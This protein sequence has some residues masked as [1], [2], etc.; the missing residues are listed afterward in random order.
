[1]YNVTDSADTDTP[2]TLRNAINTINTSTDLTNTITISPSVVTIVLTSNLP[3]ISTAAANALVTITTSSSA[4]ING[5]DSFR[6]FATH[7]ASLALLNL[8]L[9]DGVA[10]GG[11]GMD[12]VQRSGGGGGGL[13]A[14]GGVFIDLGQTLTLT[15]TTISSCRA[16]GGNGGAGANTPADGIGGSGGGASWSKAAATSTTPNVG[17]GDFPGDHQDG[18]ASSEGSTGY[19]GGNGGNG[20][21]GSIGGPGGGN[22][23][24]TPAVT[25]QGGNGGYCGGG[26][27]GSSGRA[28]GGGGNGGGDGAVTVSFTEGGGGGGYGSG[29]AGGKSVDAVAAGGGGGFG[30]GG[31]GGG[32]LSFAGGAGGGGGGFGGGGGGGTSSTTPGVIGARGLG[33]SYGGAGGQGLSSGFLTAGGGG[34]AGIGGGIFVAD[35]ATLLINESVFLSSNIAVGGTGGTAPGNPG[36]SGSGLANDVFLFRGASLSFT[37][38]S[39]LVVN[40]AIQGDTA[41]TGSNIDNGITINPS[42]SGAVITLSNTNTYQGGTTISNGTLSI[43]T[44]NNIGGSTAGFSLEG[45]TLHTTGNVT[46]SG[47][48]SVT[49]NSTIFTDPAV[50]TTLSGTLTGTDSKTLTLSGTGTTSLATV[51]VNSTDVF[52]IAG[53]IGGSQTLIKSGTGTLFLTG[54]ST[55]SAGTT[56]NA[57]IVNIQNST[58]LG[59]G[60]ASVTSGTQLQVQGGITAANALALNGTGGGTGA[61]LNISGNNTFNGAITLGSATT[62]GSTAGTLTLNTISGAQALTFVGAG[63]TTV[64]GAITTGTGTL[65][66]SGTGTLTLKGAN[67][68]SGVTAINAG[69]L[70]IQNNTALGS[71]AVSLTSGAQL[72]MQGGITATNA[73]TLNGTGGGTGALLN[74]SG[75]NSYSGP[76]TLGSATTIG[77]TADT[78]TLGGISETQ[79]L[80]FT[81]AGNTTVGGAIAIATGILTKSGAGTLSLAGTSTYTGNTNVLNG[82]LI[83][84]GSIV[85]STLNLSSGTR[86]KGTGSVGPLNVSSGATVAPG[87]SIGTLNS[88][89]VTFDPG[90]IFSVEIS[91]SAASLLDVTGTATL[92]GSVEVVVDPGTYSPSGE[93][94]ILQA[95]SIS[96]N[97]DPTVIGGNGFTF[98]LNQM[99]N[100]IYLLYTFVPPPVPTSTIAT[101]G[102]SGNALKI[103]HYLNQNA[104]SSTLALL[105]GLTGGSLKSALNSVSPARNA[106]ATYITMQTAFSLSELVISHMDDLRLPRETSFQDQFVSAL[107]ADS[108]DCPTIL[109]SSQEPKNKFSVWAAGFGEFA[110]QSASLQNPSFNFISEAAL[111]GLDYYGENRVVVGGSLGYAHTHYHEDHHAGHGN[112]NY[113]FASLYGNGFIGNFY[114]S[115]AIWGIFNQTEN[116]RN[117]SFPGF[118]EKAHADIFAWQL[119][120]HLEVGYN[121]QLC[122]GNI[123]PFTSVDWAIS[124]QREYKEHGAS[125]FN[126]KQKANNSSMVRSETGLKFCEKWEK[127]WGAFFLTEKVSYIFEKP[128]GTGTV[129]SVFVGT[130]SAF[131]VT[132]VNQN[133]NLGSVGVNFLVVIGKKKP[134]EVDVGYKGEFGSQ[135]WSNELML[136]IRKVF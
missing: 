33:G 118:S 31:G 89:P 42:D 107:I 75:N 85:N 13:G 72:Q 11:N 51:A 27:G 125:P 109:A 14:G 55:Y 28:G 136:T 45:A 111:I 130:P 62:I 15:N 102:L 68:Y 93:Y 86:L 67:T 66:K 131:T 60:S 114:F 53:A 73:L 101:S 12:S 116:T 121:I 81:E 24:G 71:G 50:A 113:Y 52:T 18:G 115:P 76:I 54:A 7:A 49:D 30:G 64:N 46:T 119:L 129:N 35:G 79:N 120:P 135:Y 16:Q 21:A 133:L 3:I 19:G 106:F 78:L 80:T 32:N 124:W 100:S 91:P 112:I 97:F 87:N 99:G 8:T 57:G 39:S 65:T 59:T 25:T 103:A 127:N 70:N 36:I 48:V 108:S 96:G 1:M 38:A 117:I 77:S 17:G 84:N 82:I 134:F 6:I 5:G 123:I 83:V 20:S 105:N 61:L 47:A 29:G 74:I 98:S 4:T 63:N 9:E 10:L 23:I 56:I 41:A 2:G 110:H 128:F 43:A 69:I 104:S 88:G 44:A 58:A 94:Q 92:A 26:G 40:F 122:W 90:A 34:G 132:A 37:G 126:A 95:T 22:N